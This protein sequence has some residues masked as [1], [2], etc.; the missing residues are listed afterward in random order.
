MRIKTS[1]VIASSLRRAATGPAIL[2]I[3]NDH[4]ANQFCLVFCQLGLGKEFLYREAQR[5]LS[6]PIPVLRGDYDPMVHRIQ[7][8]FLLQST[9]TRIGSILPDRQA[10]TLRPFP[11]FEA[12]RPFWMTLFPTIH[13]DQISPHPTVHG[14]HD[15]AVA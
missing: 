2:P 13:D 6:V 3:P 9:S 5:L 7:F 1:N 15:G 10:D 8:C 11:P 14:E 12:V 4:G